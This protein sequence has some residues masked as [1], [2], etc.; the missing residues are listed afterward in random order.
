MKKSFALIGLTGT[1]GVGKD[2]VANLLNHLYGF[3]QDAFAKPLK[4][5]LKVIGI[6]E[7]ATRKEK[8]IQLDGFDF[9]FRKAAQTLGTEWGRTLQDD[10]WI[11]IAENKL[12]QA[13]SNK[14][15]DVRICF[16]DVRFENEAAMIR[17]HGGFI[18]H[19]VG[20]ETT[21]SKENSDHRSEFGI[22][23]FPS[24]IKI[25]NS[26]D[27]DNLKLNLQTP[28]AAVL[29]KPQW[30]DSSSESSDL[31]KINDRSRLL[32]RLLRNSP[33]L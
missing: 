10:L 5:M 6:H 28:V 12:L 3:D 22:K 33:T 16:S 13:K 1:A 20:R 18:F 8:E 26:S 4:D 14:N 15:E 2:T 21:V 9:S 19:I 25:D 23:F 27:M 11:K 7:P 29:L 31:K 30:I 17:K 24:D 32:R